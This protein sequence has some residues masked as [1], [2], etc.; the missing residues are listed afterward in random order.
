MSFVIDLLLGEALP[1]IIGT[2][3]A[4]AVW[5]A[6]ESRGKAKEK[7]KAAAADADRANDIEDKVDDAAKTSAAD[8]RTAD[9]RLRDHGK[10]NSN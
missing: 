5:F 7:L 10:L 3:G 4:I 9:E 1:W 6:A 8:T 2:L